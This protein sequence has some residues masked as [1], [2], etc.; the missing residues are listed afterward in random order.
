MLFCE[1]LGKMKLVLKYAARPK[2]PILLPDFPSCFHNRS[3]CALPQPLSSILLLALP[4]SL[5][6]FLKL[7]FPPSE[8]FACLG[9]NKASAKCFAAWE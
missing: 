7:V 3:V 4:F 1:Y 6:V 8:N 2:T 9:R 5:G